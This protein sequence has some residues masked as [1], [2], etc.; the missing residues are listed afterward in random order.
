M[1]I[2]FVTQSLSHSK[3]YIGIPQDFTSS[4]LESHPS[5]RVFLI[6]MILDKEL[7]DAMNFL[8]ILSPFYYFEF[9]SISVLFSSIY[10]SLSYFWSCT[11]I[12]GAG[13]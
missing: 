2:F 8:Q 13:L 5:K 4:R 9:Y 6:F 11:S 12:Q 1:A 10:E 3:Y 7:F